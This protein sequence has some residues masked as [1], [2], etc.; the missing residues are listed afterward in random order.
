MDQSGDVGSRGICLAR[1][2]RM[3]RSSA[4][5]V[6]GR[7]APKAT[8]RAGIAVLLSLLA[9]LVLPAAASAAPIVKVRGEAVPIPGF[10]HTGNIL[11][12]GAAV[13]AEVT[14]S[15]SEYAG[16]PPPL[17]GV[18][19]WLPSG[20]KLHPQ[21]FPTCPVHVI[22]EEG[23][24]GKC[25]EG[26]S[27]GPPGKVYGVVTFGAERV[28][29]TAE[30]HAFFIP[31]DRIAFLTVGRSPVSLEVP[32]TGQ[33]EDLAGGE[34]FGPKL[35]TPVPLVATVPGAP[36]ASVE[37]IDITLGAAYREGAKT[38]YY[39]RVPSRCPRGFPVRAQLT[40][41]EDG[42]PSRPEVVSVD[43]KAPCPRS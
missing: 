9:T 18:T 11:G 23:L 39:G 15:G 37:A 16:A 20:V 42:E 34:G 1:A 4:D 35:V 33:L 10:A 7:C 41:A 22:L 8:Y 31:G 28:P 21:G 29:E 5:S 43:F 2:G 12:A 40:F 3:D 6:G 25:P 38:I 27:A 36:Y 17:I 14:I 19:A 32:T 26:S 24:P 13:H 30:I